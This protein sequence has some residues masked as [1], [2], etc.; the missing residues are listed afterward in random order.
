MPSPPVPEELALDWVPAGSDWVGVV[1]AAGGAAL[2][3]LV[4]W[5]DEPVPE[6]LVGASVEA[7]LSVDEWLSLEAVPLEAVPPET[8]PP[9]VLAPEL[10]LL[11]LVPAVAEPDCPVM[12]CD[13]ALTAEPTAELAVDTG[14]SAED[15]AAP[16][17]G[18]GSVA[19]CACREN[20]SMIRKIPAAT[21]ASCTA[22]RAMRRAIGC[23][24]SCSHPPDT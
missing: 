11:E 7:V 24:I 23:G 14:E 4:A 8:V 2:G 1:L 18:G 6:R 12:A 10:A 16:E 21:I 19:A 3:P 13:A 22:R 20:T 9:D 5:A 15:G 17:G